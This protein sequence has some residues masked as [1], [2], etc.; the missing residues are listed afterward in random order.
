MKLLLQLKRRWNSLTS[1][2]E[3]VGCAGVKTDG[4]FRECF[5]YGKCSFE[6]EYFWLDESLLDYCIR[7]QHMIFAQGYSKMWHRLK[8]Q[9][10]SI[11][12]GFLSPLGVL[13]GPCRLIKKNFLHCFIFT[14][15]CDEMS[16]FFFFFTKSCGTH[17]QNQS[18]NSKMHKIII[19]FL[20]LM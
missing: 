20:C 19:K 2:G 5:F 14:E 12:Q 4:H 15:N 18:H 9:L 10:Q 13:Y 7:Y 8:M 1:H 6:Q 17:I 16:F 3:V 11:L